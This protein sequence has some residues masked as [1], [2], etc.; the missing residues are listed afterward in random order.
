LLV[1]ERVETEDLLA[2]F[3]HA[4]TVRAGLMLV[5]GEQASRRLRLGICWLGPPH[6]SPATGS[7]PK[8]TEI[9]NGTIA[10]CFIEVPSTK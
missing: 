1:T 4:P 9:A 5:R 8:R 10:R 7:I 6:A 3:N 2:F